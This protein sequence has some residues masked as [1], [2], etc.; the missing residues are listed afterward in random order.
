MDVSMT[1]IMITI[2]I[3][4]YRYIAGERDHSCVL[5]CELGGGWLS[6]AYTICHESLK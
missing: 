3:Y 5:I 2:Y 6:Y 1:H 4:I